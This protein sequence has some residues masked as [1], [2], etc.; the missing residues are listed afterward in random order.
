M[1]QKRHQPDKSVQNGFQRPNQTGYKRQNTD[2]TLNDYYDNF[3][4]RDPVSNTSNETQASLSAGNNQSI[5]VLNN[6]QKEHGKF[7]PSL[8]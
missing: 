4:T 8:N 2:T 6:V 5:D 1:L 7:N 3:K